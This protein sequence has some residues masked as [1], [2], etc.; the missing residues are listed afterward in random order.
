MLLPANKKQTIY[1]DI[2]MKRMIDG[3]I[4][5]LAESG[6]C[7][8]LDVGEIAANIAFRFPEGYWPISLSSKSFSILPGKI[9]HGDESDISNSCFNAEGT[10]MWKTV[11]F[12]SDSINMGY[13]YNEIMYHFTF[14]NLPKRAAFLK[15]LFGKDITGNEENI[16]PFS[17]PVSMLL[18]AFEGR[19]EY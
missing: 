12:I 17:N 6:G 18:V 3:I 2:N 10:V 7:K 4:N 1:G 13:G 16:I 19:M 5:C 14:V 9:N 8:L 11:G 15:E